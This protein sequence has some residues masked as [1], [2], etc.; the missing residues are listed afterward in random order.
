[1]ERERKA[2]RI[3]REDSGDREKRMGVFEGIGKDR[4]QWV[5]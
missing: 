4:R 2:K 3:K 5:I 1:M